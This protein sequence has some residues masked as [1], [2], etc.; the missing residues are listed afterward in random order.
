LLTDIDN[1]ISNKS[2]EIDID[3][4]GNPAVQGIFKS[5]NNAIPTAIGPKII[6]IYAQIF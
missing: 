5:G 3:E 2:V 1:G 6:R 4:F